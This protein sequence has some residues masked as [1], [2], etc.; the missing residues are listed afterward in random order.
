MTDTDNRKN[1]KCAG[2]KVSISKENTSHKTV[3]NI[4]AI[5]AVF[6]IMKGYRRN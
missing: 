5:A 2:I 4:F 1:R 6:S 3:L